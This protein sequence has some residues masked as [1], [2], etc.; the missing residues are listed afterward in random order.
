MMHSLK[1]GC[2]REATVVASID[3]VASGCLQIVSNYKCSYR[4]AR[5]LHMSKY[6]SVIL[7]KKSLKME[8]NI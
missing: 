6:N 8:L 1:L 2:L 4:G 3:S 5:C 7:I